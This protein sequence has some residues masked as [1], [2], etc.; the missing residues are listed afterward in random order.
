[1]V[2]AFL[3]EL[4]RIS[5]GMA[6]NR[7]IANSPQRIHH[8]SHHVD[9]VIVMNIEIAVSNTMRIERGIKACWMVLSMKLILP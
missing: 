7:D 8:F 3:K 2:R 1:M 4:K 9:I 6:T 5:F